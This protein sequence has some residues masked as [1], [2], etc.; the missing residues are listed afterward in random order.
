MIDVIAI[1]LIIKSSR[2]KYDVKDASVIDSDTGYDVLPGIRE[3]HGYQYTS[4]CWLL[5]IPEVAWCLGRS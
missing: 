5:V 1:L 3:T 4:Q 2:P